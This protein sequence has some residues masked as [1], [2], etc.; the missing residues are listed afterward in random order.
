MLYVKPHVISTTI[1]QKLK[2]T[3][4]LV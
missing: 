2:I 1:G 3:K 4:I